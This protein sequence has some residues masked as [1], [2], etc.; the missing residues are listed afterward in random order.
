M[1][2]LPHRRVSQRLGVRIGIE[3][4]GG[5]IFLT[6]VTGGMGE[7]TP[8]SVPIA[9]PDGRQSLRLLAGGYNRASTA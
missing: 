5:D 2:P 6:Q 9:E 4:A 8:T 3:T 7:T 1:S